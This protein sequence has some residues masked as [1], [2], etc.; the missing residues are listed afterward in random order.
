MEQ[1]KKD[2]F[3]AAQVE[4]RAPLSEPEEA[5]RKLREEYE[6]MSQQA[7]KI[8]MQAME[9]SNRITMEAEVNHLIM[10]QVFNAS[11]DGIC[12]IDRNYKILKMNKRLLD[13]LGKTS[14]Q[15]IGSKC[16]DLFPSACHDEASCPMLKIM[17]G[18]GKVERDRSITFSSGQ[19]IPFMVTATPLRGL[20][21]SKI[22]IV[23]TFTDITALK[24]AEKTLQRANMELERLATQDCLTQ[25]ANRRRFNDY[26]ENEWRRQMREK[27]PIAMVMCDVDFFKRYNDTYG[28]QTGDDCLRAVSGAI[29]DS[30]HRAADMGARYGGEEFVMVLPAT[31]L[32][33]AIQVAEGV[34]RRVEALNIPHS[35]SDAAEHLTISLGVSC[36]VPESSTTPQM[37]I[38]QADQSLYRAKQLGRNRVGY[39]DE[40]LTLPEI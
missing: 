4:E 20:D 10:S 40:S 18:E 27:K 1:V 25:L 37:L 16:R 8:M 13:L 23:E 3:G 33:G 19:C 21:G 29:R 22:G 32:N 39:V 17:E 12:A 6:A 7:D 28:H 15:V 34:R 2:A 30:L 11:N 24:E 5:L 35:R 26:L 14:T 38:E 9:R 31:D 36:M